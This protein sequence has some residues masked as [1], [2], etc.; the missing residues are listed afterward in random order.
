MLNKKR[1][2]EE[3]KEEEMIELFEEKLSK[4]RKVENFREK[5]KIIRQQKKIDILYYKIRMEIREKIKN[6]VESLNIEWKFIPRIKRK[7][8]KNK[9]WKWENGKWNKVYDNKWRIEKW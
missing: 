3:I 9:F 4:K 8:E 1:K 5:R 7:D 6:E 2:Y